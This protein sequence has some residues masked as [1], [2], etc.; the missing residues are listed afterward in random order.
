MKLSALP[1]ITGFNSACV[2]FFDEFCNSSNVTLPFYVESARKWTVAKLDGF[3]A[4][5]MNGFVL[6][7]IFLEAIV[8]KLLF[9]SKDKNSDHLSRQD[10][11]DL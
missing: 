3:V 5:D 7:K 9:A 4:A 2:E 1:A 10:S 8:P 6:W 11:Y